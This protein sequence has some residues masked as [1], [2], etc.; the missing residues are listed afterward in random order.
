MVASPELL[1]AYG[2]M[3]A[4]QTKQQAWFDSIDKSSRA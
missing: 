1:T 2:A 3:P 4:D